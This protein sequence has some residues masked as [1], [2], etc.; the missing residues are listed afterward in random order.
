LG[1]AKF[2]TN[3]ILDGL[4]SG[5]ILLSLELFHRHYRQLGFSH[6]SAVLVLVT[7]LVDFPLLIKLQVSHELLFL[8]FGN[9][10]GDILAVLEVFGAIVD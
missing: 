2:I 7:L 8:S 3:T 1:C 4:E 10:F 5:V 6:L 9:S